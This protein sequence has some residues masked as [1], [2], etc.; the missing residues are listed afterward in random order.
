MTDYTVEVRKGNGWGSNTFERRTLVG[1]K[2]LREAV[3]IARDYAD[4][5]V[6]GTDGWVELDV[7]LIVP[8]AAGPVSVSARV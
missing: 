4:H 7:Y 2:R 1:L 5:W 6:G 8:G 3:A